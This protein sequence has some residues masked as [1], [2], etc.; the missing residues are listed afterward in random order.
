MHL[1]RK[2]ASEPKVSVMVLE[3]LFTAKK[4][5]SR[6]LDMLAL[7][8]LVSLASV[9]LAYFIFPE[10]AG[11]V[12]PLLITVGMTPV[13]YRIFIY[14]EK[15]EVLEEGKEGFAR[16]HGEIVLIF[17]LFFIGVFISVF[18]VTLAL[19]EEFSSI[20]KPQLDAVSA[21]KSATGA[22]LSR[23]ILN[24]II[25]NNLKVI[26]FAFAASLVF[27][28]GSIWILAWNASVL[29]VYL[30]D[31]LRREMFSQF[32]A[33]SLGLAP[34]APL[35]FASFFLA[36]IAGG[37]ISAAVVRERKN[38]KAL[39]HVLKES[40]LLFA[41]SIIVMAAAAALEVYA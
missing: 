13:F 5:E 11:V 25:L 12:F 6:P 17:S 30:A 10:Y 15:E 3:S 34:H 19:P 1:F 31:L 39:L 41:L 27:G 7:S 16:R 22:A 36:G 24:T 2:D 23:E 26:A 29:A 20:I 14:E 37:F 38:M 32:A 21:A 9:L 35:E 28:V 33:S 40:L 8:I 4:I 18:L